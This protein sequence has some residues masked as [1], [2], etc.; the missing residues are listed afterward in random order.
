MIFSF[1]LRIGYFLHQ[2]KEA[3]IVMLPKSSKPTHHITSHRP[4]SLLPVLSKVF[5]KLLLKRPQTVLDRREI[6]PDLKFGLW[7]KHGTH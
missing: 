7:K 1:I 4:I 3:Q 5:A 6:I 2:W